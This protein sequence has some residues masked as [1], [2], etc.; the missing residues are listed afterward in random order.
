MGVIHESWQD[1][2]LGL[3]VQVGCR[4]FPVVITGWEGC[5]TLSHPM[6]FGGLSLGC[7]SG[8]GGIVGTLAGEEVVKL[9]SSSALGMATPQKTSSS[10]KVKSLPHLQHA[11]H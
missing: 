11:F 5:N 2:P 4:V 1:L 3:K 9:F 8:T 7:S 6:N 10:V